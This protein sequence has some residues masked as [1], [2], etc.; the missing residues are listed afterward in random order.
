[1]DTVE[2]AARQK[3]Y[4]I[5]ACMTRLNT[6]ANFERMRIRTARLPTNYFGTTQVLWMEKEL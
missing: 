1:M 3:G 5:I 2:Q 6:T 4:H